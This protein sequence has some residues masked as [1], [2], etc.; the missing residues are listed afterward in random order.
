MPKANP[1]KR[2]LTSG[3][4]ID[5]ALELG[6]VLRFY[7]AGFGAAYDDC[8]DVFSE[9]VVFVDFCVGHGFADGELVECVAEGCDFVAVKVAVYQ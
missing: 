1:E 4:K 6:S 5:D 3:N 8:G 9:L 2:H 7:Y